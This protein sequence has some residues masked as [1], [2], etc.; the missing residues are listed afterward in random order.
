MLMIIKN[1]TISINTISCIIPL[2]FTK[3]SEIADAAPSYQ[4]LLLWR[5]LTTVIIIPFAG[6]LVKPFFVCL[7]SLK[8]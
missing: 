1:T 7:V 6:L 8:K 4:E 5:F 3:A 2:P